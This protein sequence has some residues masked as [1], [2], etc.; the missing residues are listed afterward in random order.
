MPDPVTQD[1]QELEAA[2][3]AAPPQADQPR[4]ATQQK[5]VD[6]QDAHQKSVMD[7]LG[8]PQEIRAQIQPKEAPEEEVPA[9]SEIPPASEPQQVP[10]E[11]DDDDDDEGEQPPEAA[12]A[13]PEQRVDK[14]TKRIKRLTRQKSELEQ[15]LAYQQQ[16]IQQLSQQQQEAQPQE[17]RAPVGPLVN[18]LADVQDEQE[19]DRRLSMAQKALR[20]L[21]ANKDGYDAGDKF[22]TPEEIAKDL[23]TAQ[24]TIMWAPTRRIELRDDQLRTASFWQQKNQWDQAVAQFM[25]DV[26]KEGTPE[27]NQAIQYFQNYPILHSMPQG[28]YAAA[29]MIEGEKALKSRVSPGGT[30]K[31]HRDISEK[32]FS[33]RVPIAPHTANPPTRAAR[34]SSQAQLNEAMSNLVNDPDGSTESLAKVFGAL[35]KTPKRPVGQAPVRS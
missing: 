23:A 7:I 16:L 10:A 34:P 18:P 22:V 12:A 25:P 20:W 5:S 21:N 15:Q 2:I 9:P 19:L 8:I 17:E 24:E 26:F 32:A 35:S 6:L 29:L 27:F 4:T 14:R 13:Q 28:V 1:G 3:P 30:Q 11:E 31:A 33:P